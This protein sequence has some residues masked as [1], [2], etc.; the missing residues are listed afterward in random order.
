MDHQVLYEDGYEAGQQY[1]EDDEYRDAILGADDEESR[2]RIDAQVLSDV[3]SGVD[4]DGTDREV[5]MSGFFDG[6]YG[7]ERSPK[8]PA[9]P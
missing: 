2:A 5:F 9:A 8:I 7:R 3:E 6:L 4:L 1:R